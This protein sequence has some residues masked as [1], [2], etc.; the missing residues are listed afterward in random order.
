MTVVIPVIGYLVIFNQYFIDYMALW[1]PVSHGVST[2]LEGAAA[3]NIWRLIIIYYGLIFVAFGSL[4]YHFWCP[5]EI[6]QYASSEDYISIVVPNITDAV[7]NKI[8]GAL[9]K[10]DSAKDDV[11]RISGS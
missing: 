11:S 9:S 4:I 1:Q 7:Y 5:L 2:P 10:Y 8:C 6:K 3:S